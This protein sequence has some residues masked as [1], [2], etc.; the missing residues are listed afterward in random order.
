[1]RILFL[2]HYYPPEIG[3][4]Q[5]RISELAQHLKT[6]GHEVIILT[7]F[8][9]YPTGVVASGYR[10]KFFLHETVDGISV[11]RTYVF[12]SPKRGFVR[13][14]LS[15]LSFALSSILASSAVPACDLVITECPPLVLGVA[16]IMFARLKH[17]RHVF[18]V[19][20][21]FPESAIEMGVLKNWLLI[22]VAH[23]MANLIYRHSELLTVTS[24]GQ[25]ERL[26]TKGVPRDK[27][28]F[29][30]N[31][32][33]TQTFQPTDDQFDFRGKLG[34]SGAFIV[35]YG[36]THGLPQGLETLIEAAR[37]LKQETGIVFLF[38]GEGLMK[39]RLL[40]LAQS[41]QLENT[42]FINPQARSLMPDLVNSIDVGVI[43]LRK[44]DVFAGV[45]PSKMFEYMACGK[46]IIG[47]VHGDS[48]RVIESA[49]CGIAVDPESPGPFAEAVLR[50]AQES[51]TRTVMGENGR[52][53]VVENFSRDH[54]AKKL[55]SELS[56]LV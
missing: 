52:R 27:I 16:G 17:A 32:V 37:L 34:L 14:I 20:D 56:R 47:A 19:A 4:P 18:N 44:L 25:E 28:A 23:G 11:F 38:A 6:F 21:L 8:P 40:Q 46:P 36:G 24:L 53:Y 48:R 29:V 50:L 3:A 12:P 30:P 15:E 1:M 2:T 5:A 43:S 10:G 7:C 42:R 51:Q 41:Y 31:G 22:T 55:E 13:R 9:N 26:V 39:P 33:D 35:F 54:I 49:Q 45:L